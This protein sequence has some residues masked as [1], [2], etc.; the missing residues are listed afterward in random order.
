MNG[1]LI[2]DGIS[3]SDGLQDRSLLARV[4]Y[5]LIRLHSVLSAARP[6]MVVAIALL[7]LAEPALAQGLL[8]G[9]SSKPI[10]AIQRFA[11]YAVWGTLGMGIFG[12][13]WAGWN[14]TSQRPWGGQLIGGGICLGISGVI[15][16]VN[17]VVNGEGPEILDW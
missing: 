2:L 17:S 16:F 9:D 8:N 12:L 14:K 7:A 4:S 15:A 3:V 6:A 13:C 5:G 10:R 1:P 11:E